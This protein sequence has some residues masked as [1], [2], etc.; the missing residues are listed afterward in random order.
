MESLIRCL[1][2]ILLSLGSLRAQ[3]N[4]LETF[5][6]AGDLAN[7][8]CSALLVEPDGT[9]WVGHDFF[10]Q[11]S[12]NGEPISRR[13]P[14]GSWDYPFD[15][16]T[17]SSPVVNGNPY[18]WASFDI[19]E[20]HRA[21][22]STI[23][24]VSST[25]NSS[26][27]NSSP[28]L[29]SYKNGSFT[30]HHISLAN[31][32]NKGAVHTMLVDGIGDLWFGCE[33]GLVRF[34]QA[35]QQFSSYNP[36]LINLPTSNNHSSKRIFSLDYDN[37]NNILA[38]S[39]YP[40]SLNGA[41]SCLRIF[42]PQTNNWDYW[43]HQDAP[44]RNATQV[45]YA[46]VDVKASRDKT[47][48]VWVAS[49]GGGLYWIDNSNWS[50]HNLHQ[51]ADFL[52]GW[53]YGNFVF[54]NIYTNLP[55]FLSQ[56]YLDPEGALWI[57]AWSN[58]NKFIY[59]PKYQQPATYNGQSATQHLFGYKH[60]SLLYNN[61]GSQ[62][63]S[64]FQDMA[65]Y[66]NE[67][68]LAAQ[69]GLEH[70]Y[71][72]SLNPDPAYIGL[73]GA[74]NYKGVAGFNTKGNQV[75][76]PAKTA[77]VVPG[78]WPGISVDTAYYYLATTDYEQINSTVD[79]G[80]V[81]NG[82]AAGFPATAAALNNAGYS[83]E[84][85]NLRFSA[86]GLGLDQKTIDWDY[87]DSL[88]TRTYR[89]WYSRNGNGDIQ[90]ESHFEIRLGQHLLFKGR[91]PDFHLK[92]RYNRFGYL[93][94]SLGG[95]TEPTPLIPYPNIT[96]PAAAD[97]K[98]SIL[99]DLQGNGVS[100]VFRTIQL[101][102]DESIATADRRGGIFKV[103]DAYL[104]RENSPASQRPLPL[105]GDYHIGQTVNADYPD[106]STAV[107]D[108]HAR[109]IACNVR[110]TVGKGVYNEQI[111]IGEIEGNALHS[112]TF[113]GEDRGATLEFSPSHSDSNYVVRV[114]ATDHL[115]FKG[116]NFKNK[117][118]NYAK[119]FDLRGETE[120]FQLLECEL[121]AHQSAPNSPNAT[122]S[123][124]SLFTC[125]DADSLKVEGTSFRFGSHALDLRG[126]DIQLKNNDFEGNTGTAIKLNNSRNS[127][128][129]NNR[130]WGPVAGNFKGIS[131]S[132][133][134]LRILNNQILNQTANCTG[135]IEATYFGQAL[136]GD[137]ILIVNNE[138]AVQLG[139][140]RSAVTSYCDQLKLLY[141]SIQVLGNNSGTQAVLNF[142]QKGAWIARN[143][144]ISNPQ[145]L[146]F[147]SSR[148]TAGD[149][150]A[151]ADYNIY[152]SNATHPFK[153][154]TGFGPETSHPNLA[155]FQTAS[156]GDANS[157][158]LDPQFANADHLL[159]LNNAA[160]NQGLGL[161][162][163]REDRLGR[164][165]DLNQPD[166]GCYEFD[167]SGWIGANGSDWNDPQN[168]SDQKVPTANS[169]VFIAPQNH[170]PRIDASVQVKEFI[171]HHRATLHI[172]ANSGLKVDSLLQ[173]GG[174]I[175]LEA[176]TNGQYARLIQNQIAGGGRIRQEAILRAPDSSLRWFHLG[177]PVRTKVSDLANAQT[178][179][180]AGNSGASI[181]FW[182][183]ISG[184][185]ESPTDTAAW[186][187]PGRAYAVAAGSNAYGDFLCAEF[188]A[189]ID[190]GG[191]LLAADSLLHL[192]L[193]YTN[194][195]SFNSYV[196][197][198]SD[199]WN[200]LANPYHASYDMQNQ[201]LPGTYK[202]IYVWDGSR[203]K[204]YN[205][206]LDIG[207]TEARFIAPLQG[208]FI[209]TDSLQAS[210]GFTFDP[211]QRDLQNLAS[212][213]KGPN[214]KFTL[215]LENTAAK[216]IDATHFMIHPTA[217][218][219][220]EEDK[221]AAK[222]PNEAMHPNF[223]SYA[224]NEKVAINVLNEGAA[225]RGIDLGIESDVDSTYRLSLSS[226]YPSQYEYYL[227]DKLLDRHWR[228]DLGD[229]EFRHLQAQAD[230]RFRLFLRNRSIEVSSPEGEDIY[231]HYENGKIGVYQ[232]PEKALEIRL[233]QLNGQEWYR[234]QKR[235]GDSKFF[236]ACKDLQA[237]VLI[238]HI[239]ALQ[240][241]IKVLIH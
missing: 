94:D 48:R 171:M 13:A 140:N 177:T 8:G 169:K 239:E 12:L 216:E 226:D 163:I 225:L 190:L 205:T 203:Y 67:I 211:D 42:D 195:P 46:P 187:E 149:A 197:Q 181:Y 232:L 141:N 34:N 162:Q 219:S 182:N 76:E 89:E 221:D 157:L 145:G 118:S 69:H 123:N 92:I 215:K 155:A 85:L 97:I 90:S 127:L 161:S 29:L 50:G 146:C 115:R 64:P 193:H 54:D 30:V 88:E 131:G 79:A 53:S 213:Q 47:N 40:S 204:Q 84:D 147:Y 128:V 111:E 120:A 179:I 234:G 95:Y 63:P 27:M 104:R 218:E 38:I 183:A 136:P 51:I 25:G 241:S 59:T 231:V 101:A 209:R 60:C 45:F 223:F 214:P 185:W 143:N 70:Y 167:G 19:Q 5:N 119:V 98:D 14:D 184:S 24:F 233:F 18:S 109:G 129:Q 238:L 133:H 110:F 137:T 75:S 105:C 41:Q 3:Y 237:Q 72:D 74:R 236:I 210:L 235:A 194:N 126:S 125:A 191:D 192:D 229:Y 39:G 139:S 175:V 103:Y 198:I 202:T 121:E 7:D 37:Q 65:F 199:G 36:P 83:F 132:G 113:D 168:W 68:W 134:P 206:D 138:L 196:S 142:G 200:F 20:I 176:D 93:F 17:L 220:F 165:R 32:P 148:E 81:G 207:D 224:Q 33:E 170:N 73:K 117:A 55:D 166:Q 91:M 173:N 86:I 116:L 15:A 174:E 150:F 144:I 240:R 82:Y 152:Y 57:K 2:I 159:P 135:A 1:I 35:S 153:T 108:L 102:L 44:W 114:T 189:K 160:N 230:N 71:Y 31:F 21:P 217:Q 43:T 100:F 172:E 130:I 11:N 80:I 154:I 151:D 22:D 107:A 23:W 10:G 112:I 222:L 201:S 164:R 186:L 52:R 61:N 77:H 4:A 106:F 124:F 188:P 58:G 49:N 26:D 78:N 99:A 66:K 56:L 228:L 180:T 212:L 122:A 28:P 62:Q 6:S 9:L 87:H 96:D 156:G 208:F 158:F 178:H 227:E 16:N